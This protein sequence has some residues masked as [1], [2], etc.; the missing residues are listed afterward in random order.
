MICHWSSSSLLSICVCCRNLLYVYPRLLNFT[1][2][3]GSARNI[4]V[5]IQ[6]M[7]GED[8]RPL[9]VSVSFFAKTLLLVCQIYQN[10]DTQDVIMKSKLYVYLNMGD[11]CCDISCFTG[12]TEHRQ[13]L[14]TGHGCEL[15]F[16]VV[17][18]YVLLLPSLLPLLCARCFLTFPFSFC[19]EGSM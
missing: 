16:L 10:I 13:L 8:Q 17:S 19:P 18:I 14:S 9:R 11:D 15:V 2:R 12:G 6:L 4:A 7:N 3:Q 5:K 1:N